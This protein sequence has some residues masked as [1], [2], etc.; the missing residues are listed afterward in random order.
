[1]PLTEHSLQPDDQFAAMHCCCKCRY[2]TL[3]GLFRR[4]L[5]MESERMTRRTDESESRRWRRDEQ[6]AEDEAAAAADP[7]SGAPVQQAH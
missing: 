5:D 3:A 6:T 1:M 4:S 2:Q 7:K